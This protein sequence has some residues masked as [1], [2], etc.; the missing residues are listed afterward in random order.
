[1]QG[2][3]ERCADGKA[4]DHHSYRAPELLGVEPLPAG[5]W[6]QAQ[7][8]PWL[9][10]RLT[11]LLHALPL[12]APHQRAALREEERGEP[13]ELRALL[14]RLLGEE[15]GPGAAPGHLVH[16]LTLTAASDRW[17]GHHRGITGDWA[18][19]G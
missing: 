15:E 8:L 14:P 1:M 6:R 3:W 13:P 7:A 2:G 19:Q 4:R 16:A 11:G 12:A 18:V 17:A 9:L 5:L 10:H